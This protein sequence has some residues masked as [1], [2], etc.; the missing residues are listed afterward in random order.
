[1]SKTKIEWCDHSINPIR[2]RHK[3]TGAVGH[4]CEKIAAGCAACYSSAF[5]KRFGMPTFGA[6]Q[7]RDEVEIFLDE[8]KL[9]EVRRRKKPTRYFWCDMTDIFGD[10]MQAEWL[11]SCCATMDA[12][13]QHTHLLLTKR[14]ENIRKMWPVARRYPDPSPNGRSTRPDYFRENVWI[15]TSISTQADADRNIPHLLKCRDL[16][17]VL[18][19]SAEPLV[20]HVDFTT[21]AAAKVAGGRF[22]QDVLDQEYQHI[23][24]VIIGGESG[25]NARPCEIDWIR[26]LKEQCQAASVPCFIKQIGSYAKSDGPGP[27]PSSKVTTID[28]KG[29][30][31]HEWP[32]DL[33]VREFPKVAI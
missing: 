22:G 20:E 11:R 15:G 1:M 28:P 2:A 30:D 12:T 29:G 18:F 27:Y 8:S 6:G 19:V 16:S 7:H 32:I 5:Q 31:P 10:W 26:S 25:P 9:D 23:D 3:K 4:Y 21:V 17:P 13:P 14:P 24:W 33:R